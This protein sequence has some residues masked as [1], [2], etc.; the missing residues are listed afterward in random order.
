MSLLL[1]PLLPFAV[2]VEAKY[3]LFDVIPHEQLNKQRRAYMFY[4]DLA[5]RL[6]RTL[7]LPRGRLVRKDAQGRF[8][9]E[10]AEYVRWGELFNL[11]ALNKLHPVMELE[12]FLAEGHEVSLMSK[13]DHRPCQGGGRGTVDFNGLQG[14][15]VGMFQCREGFQYHTSELAALF[16]APSLGFS[17]S[18]DQMS[19][20]QALPLRRYL[21]YDNR[22]Y[23]AA[24]AFVTRQVGGKPFVAL[25]WRRTDFL[26]VRRTQPGVLQ[27]AQALVQHAR[28]LMSKAGTDQVY[29]ATDCDDPAELALLQKQLKP[30]RYTPLVPA[31]TLRARVDVANIEVAICAMAD[32]F[33]GTKTSSFSLAINEERVAIFDKPPESGGEMD[34]LS[35]SLSAHGLEP[36]PLP[37]TRARKDEL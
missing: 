28:A 22:V 3:L 13:I 18:V 16:E 33:L 20:Q 10:Q 25:H 12:T 21:R 8:L 6:K 24:A 31:E 26:Q 23:D 14:V 11:T 27:D 17:H 37:G 15:V 9:N 5:M 2:D 29:L 30:V 4:L 7:V 1:L 34:T 19:P 36:V 32:Q 35:P